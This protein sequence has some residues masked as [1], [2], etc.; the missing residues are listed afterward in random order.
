MKISWTKGLDKEQ[1]L[2]VRGNYKEALVMRRRLVVM[3]K[4]KIELSAK[5]GRSK[6]LYE[7]PN[8]AYLQADAR[9]Y[10]RAISD[11]IDLISED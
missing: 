7:S 10:E 6:E 8:W 9:G 11:V 3:L 5:A 2:D 4:D 1:Q